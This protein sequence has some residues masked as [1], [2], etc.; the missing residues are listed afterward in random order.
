MKSKILLSVGLGLCMLGGCECP[1]NPFEPSPTNVNTNSPA[2]TPVPTPTTPP[3][4]TQ[5]SATFTLNASAPAGTVGSPITFAA[6]FVSATTVTFNLNPAITSTTG[7]TNQ[8]YIVVGYNGT[9]KGGIGYIPVTGSSDTVC[10]TD[11]SSPNPYHVWTGYGVLTPG[12]GA[13]SVQF[14]IGVNTTGYSYTS[15]LTNYTLMGSA[16]GYGSNY[17]AQFNGSNSL[18]LPATGWFIAAYSPTGGDATG[19]AITITNI[20]VT[21]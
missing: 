15:G 2:A 7:Q 5:A 3:V 9:I 21:Q 20:V 14:N 1:K 12:S 19:A 10:Y 13:N 4:Y 6:S 16:I 17:G 8:L 11:T 18:G